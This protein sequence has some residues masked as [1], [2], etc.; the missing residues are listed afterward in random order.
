MASFTLD[1]LINLEETKVSRDPSSYITYLYGAV[2]CGKTTF[3]RDAGALIIACEDGT[4]AMSGAYRQIVK[5]WS[6]IKAIVKYLK[7]P[8]LKEKYKAVA[9]DTIDIAGA[10]CEKYVCSQLEIETLGEGGWSKNGW[11]TFKKELTDVFNTI[12]VEGYAIIF[13][14]HDKEKLITRPDGTEFTKIVPSASES[15]SS[16]VKGMSDM[17]IYGYQEYGT[18]KRYMV[19][20]SDQTIEAGTRF[21][22]MK[23]KI[24][25]G[26]DHLVKAL[27]DAIDEEEKHGGQI[28]EERTIAQNEEEVPFDAIM[29]DLQ[30]TINTL[31]SK[32]TANADKIKAIV[33]RYLGKG[34]KVSDCTEKQQEV[35]EFVLSELKDLL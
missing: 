21:P 7:D 14:S 10:L 30:N 4:R 8:R 6:D 23:E 11:A 3:A 1:D 26:Y 18:D 27:N 35:V 2:K 24:P 32:D 31:M 29:S 28:T 13:I 25:F 22:Y 15:I 34:K 17:I 16:I 5:S 12:S 33:E 20:R 9:F 19:L